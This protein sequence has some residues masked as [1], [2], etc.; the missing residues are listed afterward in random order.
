[1]HNL[2]FYLIFIMKEDKSGGYPWSIIKRDGDFKLIDSRDGKNEVVDIIADIKP[3]NG[4]GL[5][6][7]TLKSGDEIVAS[8]QEFNATFS[9]I[10]VELK[11]LSRGD[12][13]NKWNR[14]KVI[15]SSV[16]TSF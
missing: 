15:Q 3:G 11:T 9:A 12:F 13:Q 7:V 1:M 5:V 2:D 6:R 14:V 4:L 10:A 8:L 16:R